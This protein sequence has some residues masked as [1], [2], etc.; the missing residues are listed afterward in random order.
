MRHKEKSKILYKPSNPEITIQWKHNYL[1]V[2][3]FSSHHDKTLNNQ[4]STCSRFVVIVR[5]RLHPSISNYGMMLGIL[6]SLKTME[7]LA[8]VLQPQFVLNNEY[9]IAS[10]IAE[11]GVNGPQKRCSIAIKK[12]KSLIKLLMRLKLLE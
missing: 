9:T 3:Q 2:T 7:S 12:Y 5:H 11:L 8:N 6:L 10:S 4:V 1:M